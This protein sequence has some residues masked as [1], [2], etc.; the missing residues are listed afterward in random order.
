MRKP[1]TS[2]HA[3]FRTDESSRPRPFGPSRKYRSSGCSFGGWISSDPV[4]GSEAA[5]TSGPSGGAPRNLDAGLRELEAGADR[6]HVLDP[7]RLQGFRGLGAVLLRLT[8]VDVRRL[9]GEVGENGDHVVGYLR[10]PG[11]DR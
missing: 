3:I 6:L 1:R 5:L 8:R 11:R 9:L 2:S 10:E 4:R 7:R